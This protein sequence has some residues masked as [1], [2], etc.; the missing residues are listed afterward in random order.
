MK[1]IVIADDSRTARAFIRRCLEI[2]G[3]RDAIFLEVE[4]GDQ[5]LQILETQSV[6][7]LLT[8][9]TMIG[10]DGT[11]L[12]RRIRSD[13]KWGSMPI[14]VITSAKNVAKQE[15]LISLGANV[16]LRKP[17]SPAIMAQALQDICLAEVE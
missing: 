9:L 2:A 11:E 5:A 13:G 15:E 17:V 4:G 12:V 14:I 8:D 6:D 10:I 1:T 3:Q 7:L 16:V